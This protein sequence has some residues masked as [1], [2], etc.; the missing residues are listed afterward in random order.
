MLPPA[1]RTDANN[2]GDWRGES[3]RGEGGLDDDD[4]LS[5]VQNYEDE[6]G[7]GG[8]K[9]TFQMADS[10]PNIADRIT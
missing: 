9:Q 7:G 2:D 4:L 8:Q 5:S 6:R 10:M 1:R 3:S